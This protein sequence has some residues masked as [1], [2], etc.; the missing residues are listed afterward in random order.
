VCRN[1][2]HRAAYKFA[3]FL[4]QVA[5]IDPLNRRYSIGSVDAEL[6]GWLMNRPL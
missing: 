5:D 2:L 4:F 6:P 3:G 1:S